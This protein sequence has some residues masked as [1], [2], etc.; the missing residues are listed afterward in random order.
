MDRRQLIAA[1]A[2]RS[3]LSREQVG[4]ALDALLETLV[5]ALAEGEIVALSS[6][7]RFETQVYPA[8]KLR[9]FDGA[10]HYTVTERRVPVFKSSAA[11]RRRL[12][13]NP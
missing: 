6:F 11:L 7:G 13:E 3:R 10:G 4:Q 8:R 9:R 2:R 5:V 1:A 12:R